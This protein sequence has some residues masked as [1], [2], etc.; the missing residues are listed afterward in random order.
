[1]SLT[2]RAD[3]CARFRLPGVKTCGLHTWMPTLG[4]PIKQPKPP[5]ILPPRREPLTHVLLRE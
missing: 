2:C 5:L 1:M 3:K 4:L